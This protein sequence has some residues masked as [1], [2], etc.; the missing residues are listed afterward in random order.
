MHLRHQQLSRPGRQYEVQPSSTQA[1]KQASNGLSSSM[2]LFSLTVVTK[3]IWSRSTAHRTLLPLLAQ[4][5]DRSS[6]APVWED[7]VQGNE[8]HRFAAG[9]AVRAMTERYGQSSL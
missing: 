7:A 9:E 1:S 3:Q 6:K 2:R 5:D 4:R 8:S